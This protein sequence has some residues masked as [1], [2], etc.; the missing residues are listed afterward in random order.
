MRTFVFAVLCFSPLIAARCATAQPATALPQGVPPQGITPQGATLQGATS[1]TTPLAP[2]LDAGLAPVVDFPGAQWTPAAESNFDHANRP[3]GQP[4]DTVVI[5][6]IEGTPQAALAIFSRIGAKVSAHYVVGGDGTIYQT[7][8]ERDIA[9]HAGNYA[10]NQRAIGIETEG[11]AYRPGFYNATQYEAEARLVRAITTRYAIPRDR[12]H[13]IGHAE[14][15]NPNDPTR[16][17]GRNGHTDPGPYWDWNAFMTLVRS[18]SHV[19]TSEL[20]TTIRPGEVLPATVTFVNAGDDPWF[21]NRAPN[22]LTGLE[23]GGPVLYLGS[24]T[25]KPSPLSNA[26]T[27]NSPLYAA[28]LSGADVASGG[29]ARFVFT[30]RGPRVIGPYREDL[31]LWTVPTAAQGG[32]PLAFGDSLSLSLN[33]LPWQFIVSVPDALS[34]EEKKLP[35]S[36]LSAVWTSRLPL[37]GWWELAVKPAR[38]PRRDLA[39]IYTVTTNEQPAIVRPREVNIPQGTA[40][41]KVVGRFFCAEPPVGQSAPMKVESALPKGLK[42]EDAGAV[43][44]VGPFPDSFGTTANE[45]R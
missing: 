14:V 3:Q 44:W 10:V 35:Q 16:F 32:T 25:G 18:Q 11:Y 37:G 36:A 8:R 28:G 43:R 27:W 20:P 39:A 42:R 45:Q 29:S 7:V 23:A 31:R 40:D 2:P 38:V 6:D 15:P 12:A 26:A 21:A 22:P 19:Q 9:W 13:I 1:P 30:V 4:I 17:G 41:W 5:H 34:P 33:V 24:L